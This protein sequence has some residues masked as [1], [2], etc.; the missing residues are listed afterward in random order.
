MSKTQ[1]PNEVSRIFDPYV[2]RVY[3]FLC[4]EAEE[5]YFKVR[6]NRITRHSTTYGSLNIEIS[7]DDGV[8]Y[9][10]VISLNNR[11][12]VYRVSDGILNKLFAGTWMLDIVEWSDQLRHEEESRQNLD[13]MAVALQDYNMKSQVFRPL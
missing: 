9:A 6:D 5:E 3:A 2:S 8:S 1:F 13:R 10:M 12:E 11:C 4:K 7:L